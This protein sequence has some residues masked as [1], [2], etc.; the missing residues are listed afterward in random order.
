[1]EKYVFYATEEGTPQG[2]ICTPP[3]MLQNL[4]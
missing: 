3:T 1:M 4:P 2:G